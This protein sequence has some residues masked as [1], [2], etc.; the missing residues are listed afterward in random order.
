[1]KKESYLKNRLL[2]CVEEADAFYISAFKVYSTF[3]D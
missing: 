3:Q 2:I 1:M